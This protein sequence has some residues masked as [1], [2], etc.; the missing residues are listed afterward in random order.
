MKDKI[1]IFFIYCGLLISL[2]GCSS[3]MSIKANS[4]AD[5]NNIIQDDENRIV[6][7]VNVYM[8]CT[9]LSIRT[10]VFE[11]LSFPI[12]NTNS[13]LKI[14]NDGKFSGSAI[15]NSFS[16]KYTKRGNN[17]NFGNIST[18]QVNCIECNDIENLITSK[19]SEV[20]NFVIDNK[21]LLL[22]RDSEV[23]MIYRI[24]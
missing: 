13:T 11:N 3:C 7:A 15:R 10:S 1:F 14:S 20:N 18:T 24:N 19:L 8:E 16:G 6:T 5:R 21:Q 2:A 17:I 9:L 22:K 23:L 12:K 4:Q